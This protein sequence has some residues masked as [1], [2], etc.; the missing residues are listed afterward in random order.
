M[1]CSRRIIGT[2][3]CSTVWDIITLHQA[4][5]IGHFNTEGVLLAY[6]VLLVPRAPNACMFF[7]SMLVLTHV[8]VFRFSSFYLFLHVQFY[9][10][11]FFYQ[12]PE[13]CVHVYPGYV[14]VLCTPAAVS[15]H[16]RSI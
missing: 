3:V 16:A 15:L 4:N 14:H 5:A 7:S 6:N 8:F 11:V 10:I 9:C 1:L 12:S 2:G 13:R